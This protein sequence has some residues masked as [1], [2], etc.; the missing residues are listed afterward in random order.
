VLFGHLTERTDTPFNGLPI[1]RVGA[2]TT[3][4]EKGN[5]TINYRVGPWTAQWQ[6][7]YISDTLINTTWVEGK[8][9]DNNTVPAYSLTN[10]MFSYAAQLKTG[11][12]WAVSLAINNAF[13]KNPP[14]FPSVFNRVGSQTGVGVGFDEFGRRYQLPVKLVF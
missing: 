3:P 5:L 4:E 14:I 7:R 12:N 11:E 13:D 10:L 6:Q 1:N 9:V 8:D 2:S